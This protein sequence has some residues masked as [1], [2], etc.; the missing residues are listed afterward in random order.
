MAEILVIKHGALGDMVLALG[1]LAAIRAH[2]PYDR[3][4][5]LTTPA[6]VELVRPSGWL[7]AIWTERRAHWWRLSEALAL[8]RRVA[9]LAPVRVYDLQGSSRTRWYR[10]FWPVARDAWLRDEGP[11]DGR[12]ARQRLRELLARGG[13]AD[14]PPPCVAFLD[15]DI[16]D[17]GLPEA[18]ALLVPS[19]G[20]SDKR[21]PV[22]RWTQLAAALRRRGFVP[23]VIGGADSPRI[24]DAVDLAGRTGFAALAA[25]ARRAR[26]AVGNDT[27]PMHLVAAAGCPVLTL[28][29]PGSDPRRSAPGWPA[30]QWLRAETLAAIGVD[31]VLAALDRRIEANARSEPLFHTQK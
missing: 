8:R 25:V 6:Y 2:H 9:D 29:G 19:A 5:L 27:G 24:A 16:S 12:H 20:K 10:R 15:T 13:I 3:L 11:P 21:W 31:E 22:A 30:G 4:T 23:V 28:F 14:V 1:A 7:D 17:L 18:F 26:F